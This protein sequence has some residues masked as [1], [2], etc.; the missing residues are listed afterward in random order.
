MLGFFG[1]SRSLRSLGA[2]RKTSLWSL[3]DLLRL[4]ALRFDL[5]TNLRSALVAFG[6]TLRFLPFIGSVRLVF[7]VCSGSALQQV[8]FAFESESG[9]PVQGRRCPASLP[10]A[11]RFMP[12]SVRALA[13][14]F[15]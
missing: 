7:V 11:A 2:D 5:R 9:A 3:R 12:G 14:V 4:S 15:F 8:I 6:R 13:P 10:D 1:Q